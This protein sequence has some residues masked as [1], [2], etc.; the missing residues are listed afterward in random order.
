MQDEL[1]PCHYVEIDPEPS[2]T[3]PPS[4]NRLLDNRSR[5]RYVPKDLRCEY[6]EATGEEFP[7]F[8]RISAGDVDSGRPERDLYFCGIVCL[9]AYCHDRFPAFSPDTLPTSIQYTESAT[10]D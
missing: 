7:W 8:Q 2:S 1:T 5:T 10:D 3:S 4:V 6:C 9:A